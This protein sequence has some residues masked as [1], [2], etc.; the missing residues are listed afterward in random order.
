MATANAFRKELVPCAWGFY[1]KQVGRLSRPNGKGW[2][3]GRCPFH[4]SKSGKSFAMH[5][6]TGGFFCHG[7]Q[8]KGGDVVSFIMQR[9]RIDFR[10]A[11]KLL[12][13]WQ[14]VSKEERLKL[15]NEV[16]RR[17][18][19]RE[20]AA[21]IKDVERIARLALREEICSLVKI[22]VDVSERLSQLLRGAAPAHENEIENCWSVASLVL[23]GLRETESTYM[24]L[25]GMEFAG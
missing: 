23:D 13:C 20:Q 21:Q 17:K 24:A 9:D 4:D 6:Q 2:A 14:G 5:L 16:A 18:Q 7:C 10:S 12:G 15:D 11:C 25:I 8:R 22:Q 1:Q 3:M 19:E